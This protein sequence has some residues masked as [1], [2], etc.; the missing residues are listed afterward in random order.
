MLPVDVR[1]VDGDGTCRAD[2]FGHACACA[3]RRRKSR[4]RRPA[5][6]CARAICASS[7]RR[8]GRAARVDRAIYQGGY[9]RLEAH[10]EANADLL[11]HVTAPEPFQ[12]VPDAAIGCRW[13]M[14]G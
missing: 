5:R 14:A 8:A 9:F 1:S 7:Q 11:L 13:R 10:V 4:R 6:A 12:L 2:L 3:A